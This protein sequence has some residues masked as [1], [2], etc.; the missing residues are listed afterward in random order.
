MPWARDFF[1]EETHCREKLSQRK[2]TLREELSTR[3]KKIKGLIFYYV[4]LNANKTFFENEEC[5]LQT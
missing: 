5:L 4:K 3:R 1:I 2:K